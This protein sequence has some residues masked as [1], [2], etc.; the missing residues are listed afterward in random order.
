MKWPEIII[1]FRNFSIDVGS[2]FFFL[3]NVA[4]VNSLAIRILDSR[5]E[6]DTAKSHDIPDV[7]G[8]S[9]EFEVALKFSRVS[10]CCDSYL[11]GSY[12]A[13]VN[14]LCSHVFGLSTSI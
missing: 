13:L 5:I 3:A 14:C 8:L 6:Y 7:A 11:V 1:V 9:F 12:A 4:G 2:A 10:L